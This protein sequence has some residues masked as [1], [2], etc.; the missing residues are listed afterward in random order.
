MPLSGFTVSL[1]TTA[2]QVSTIQGHVNKPNRVLVRNDSGI[3]VY[4][5]DADVDSS[6]FLLATG[7]SVEVDV[8]NEHLW[9]VA[10]SGTPDITVLEH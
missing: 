6:S 2:A 10:A 4:L 9:A 5:G 3:N 8:V 1:S 7:E